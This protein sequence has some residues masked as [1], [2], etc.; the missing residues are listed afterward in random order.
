MR[1]SRERERQQ[2]KNQL[3][4]AEWRRESA[5]FLERNKW[6]VEHLA[7]GEVVPA[8]VTD[9]KVPHRGNLQRF[10][11]RKNWQ[12][13]CKHCHDRK[14]ALEDSAWARGF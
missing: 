4:G 8:T 1:S 11:D 5:A 7:I 9:H 14:T 13:L 10:W 2:Q 6:C 3:Y 12:P